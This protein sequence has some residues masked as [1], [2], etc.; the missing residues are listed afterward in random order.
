MKIKQIDNV[1]LLQLCRSRAQQIYVESFIFTGATPPRGVEI[2]IKQLEEPLE[3]LRDTN[4]SCVKQYIVEKFVMACPY[5]RQR[6]NVLVNNAILFKQLQIKDLQQFLTEL[7][8]D[9]NVS[10]ETLL[11]KHQAMTR[12]ILELSKSSAKD[13]ESPNN[14]K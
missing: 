3:P 5:D 2:K 9:S 7:N 4:R 10:C 14:P 6:F 11:K 12:I 1:A 8:S 13:N